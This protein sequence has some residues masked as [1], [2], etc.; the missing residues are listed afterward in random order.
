MLKGK[1]VVLG[2]KGSIAAYKIANLTSMH[3]KQHA[4]VNIIKTNNT[5]KIKNTI[6]KKTKKK[7][8]KN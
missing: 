2:V 1:T 3:I 4:K 7:K 6:T 8:N 5:K